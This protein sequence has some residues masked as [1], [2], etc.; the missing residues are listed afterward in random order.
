MIRGAIESERSLSRT[1]FFYIV[2]E[3]LFSFFVS[4]LFFF[5]IFFVNQLLLMAQEILTKRVPFNQ[6]ALLVL[7]SLPSIIAMAA[8]FASLVGTLMTVGRLSSDNEVLVL[9]SSGLSYRN[10][11]LPA[12]LVGILISLV[13]FYA[14]DVLLPA[15][16]VQFSRLYRRI[17]VSTPALELE[18]NSVKRFKDT[19]VVTGDVTGNAI[20]DVLILDKTSDGER[21]VIMARSAEL[22]DGG[23]QGLSLDLDEAFIQSSKELA[24]RDYDYGSSG[25]LR[26][27]VPQEDLIQAVSSIG[28][29][30]MSSIDVWREI[31]VK[32]EALRVR[33]DQRYNRALNHAMSLELALRKGP[34]NAEWNRRTNYTLNFLRE[35]EAAEVL[36]RDRSILV[37][38]LEFYKKF[39]I[40]F[41]ALSFV[42]LAVSL[43]LLAKKSGQTV[44]FIFGLLISVIYWALLLGGQTMGIRLGY[45]P[46]WSMWL[47]N[48]LAMSVGMIM[49]LI[50]IK[51]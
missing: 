37:Y 25:F 39:S 33:L 47:P 32:E 38:R 42:F 2:S 45:S 26:Y 1:I 8:P 14:N 4:F 6:V 36:K 30:E 51:R 16:T 21:R 12:L 48:I 23:R 35:A 9:L 24:R 10:I 34:D 46:F 41:G 3:T 7:Y 11:F 40:P 22:K 50:R 13:S 43:G 27:W 31:K 20:S 28:P 15:G 44:G 18:A 49:G 19:V 29:R 5:F 17:L